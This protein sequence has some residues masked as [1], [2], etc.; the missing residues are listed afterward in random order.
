MEFRNALPHLGA[1]EW[2]VRGYK[3]D[4]QPRFLVS[5]EFHYFRVPAAD[6]ERRLKLFKETGG[7]CIATYIPWILHEPAEGNIRFGD[8]PERDLDS[9]LRLCRKLGLYVICRPGPYQYSEMKYAGLPG[10]LQQHYPELLARN[11]HGGIMVR[12]SVSYLHPVFLEKSKRW[13]DA[14]CPI[15][16]KHTVAKGGAVAYAQFDN[17]LIGV[18]EWYGGWDYNPETMGFG[19]SDGRYP[20]FLAEQYGDIAKLNL[21]YGTTFAGFADVRPIDPAAIR[22]VPDRR[23]AKDYQDFYFGTVT[24][25]ALILTN[26]MREAGIDCDFIHNSANADSNAYHYE[27]AK[28]LGSRFLLGTFTRNAR[29]VRRRAAPPHRQTAAGRFGCEHG[30]FHSNETGRIREAWRKAAAGACDP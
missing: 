25:F 9:F 20:R 5:G 8:V 19:R 21:A 26:W 7:N 3:I 17:E 30:G 16:A 27:M 15:I 29:F 4:G 24:E 10:W 23:R 22:N 2:D 14:V 13:F 1:L 6:W 12:E 28:R 11:V 18:H